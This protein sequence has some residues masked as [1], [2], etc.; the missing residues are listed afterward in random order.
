MTPISRPKDFSFL[1]FSNSSIKNYKVGNS[2]TQLD[3][4]D[5]AFTPDDQKWELNEW[6]FYRRDDLMMVTHI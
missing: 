1:F 5:D 3:D 6:M 4:C 2:S